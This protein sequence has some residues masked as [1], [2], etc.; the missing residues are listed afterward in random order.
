MNAAERRIDCQA[1]VGPQVHLIFNRTKTFDRAG[2]LV[3]TALREI[4]LRWRSQE[5]FAA[6]LGHAGFVD[7]EALGDD[8][9]WIA[10]ARRP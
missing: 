10:I 4:R 6:A 9:A 7:I 1:D 2:A 5:Q 8:D 3:D